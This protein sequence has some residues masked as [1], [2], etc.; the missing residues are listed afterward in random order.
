MAH[1]TH[2]VLHSN[3]KTASKKEM[4]RRARVRQ[5]LKGTPYNF[6]K[7]YIQQHLFGKPRG[8]AWA[9]KATAP[10]FHR[11]YLLPPFY[12]LHAYIA[13]LVRNSLAGRTHYCLPLLP[14]RRNHPPE[15]RFVL[16]LKLQT[17]T[18]LGG[19]HSKSQISEHRV[20][21]GKTTWQQGLRRS[22]GIPHPDA[23]V[24]GH[25][26]PAPCMLFSYVK[27]ALW[28]LELHTGKKKMNFF[29]FWSAEGIKCP[30]RQNKEIKLTS[31]SWYSTMFRRLYMTTFVGKKMYSRGQ[32]VSGH[33]CQSKNS[34]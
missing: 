9:K 18:L 34:Y 4:A 21:P 17:Q 2:T 27:Y 12:P 11:F 25:T 26:Y 30:C 14:S 19:D 13:R 15:Q 10:F 31:N 1:P 16:V 20:F 28:Y 22:C 6:P 23:S 7:A 3:T 5:K 32:T 24:P 33:L 8:A 29:L